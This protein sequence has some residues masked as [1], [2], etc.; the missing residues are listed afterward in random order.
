MVVGPDPAG[1]VAAALLG[2]RGPRVLLCG[3]D[4]PP[5]TFSAGPFTL[6]REPP[7][8]PPP[9]AEPVARVYAELNCAPML[10]RRAPGRF[11]A[12]Q[13]V[14]PKH[15]LD[16]PEGAAAFAR[17][18]GREFPRDADAAGEAFDR[19][20]AASGVLGALLGS[21]VALPPEGFWERREVSRFE[22]ELARAG[23]DPLA[24]LPPAHPLRAGL[25]AMAAM[26]AALAPE[27]MPGPALAR[28]IDVARRGAHLIDGDTAGLRGLVLEW[29]AAASIET[30]DGLQVAE[31]VM[32]R[33]RPAAVRVRPRDE[34]IGLEHLVWAGPIPPL[35]ALLD[36]KTG[37]RLREVGGA[38][39]PAAFRYTLCLLLRP[40]GVPAGLGAR[41]IAIADPAQ[42]LRDDNALAVTVGAPARRADRVPVWVQCLVPASAAGALGVVRARVRERLARLMPF[43]E[44]HL[45]CAASP[46]DGLPP[47]IPGTAA[48]DLTAVPPSPM[49][50]VTAYDL[51]RALGVGGVPHA[52]GVR[53]LAIASSD[54]LPGLGPEGA[55]A[56]GWAVAGAIAGPREK[57]DRPRREILSEDS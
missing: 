47:E 28:A 55:F 4:Q 3:H 21:D 57:R 48:A 52:T 43:H 30:R 38:L 27:D 12:F 20:R 10:R 32:K 41:A 11:P 33:G 40:E 17:E 9:D 23:T 24:P 49:T 7:L 54:N 46:H 15:R 39:R 25:A 2:R 37:R 45:V 31:I 51:P 22:H 35:L 13:L 44:R 53:H 6:L 14:F 50:P 56:S 29:L 26:S 8:L 18:L 16:V 5:P 36:D 34:I 1:G 19:M 42:P